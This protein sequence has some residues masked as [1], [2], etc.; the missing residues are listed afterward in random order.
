[1]NE[2]CNQIH[3]LPLKLYFKS[4][5]FCARPLNNPTW[6]ALLE[7]NENWFVFLPC[8]M[9]PV[10]KIPHQRSCE[11]RVASYSQSK[12]WQSKRT[13][14]TKM[15]GGSHINI[16]R[17][18]NIIAV[19]IS[20]WSDYPGIGIN[21]VY[22]VCFLCVGVIHVWPAFR[23][24]VSCLNLCLFDLQLLPRNRTTCV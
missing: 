1:M 10:I 15:F 5:Q 17:F 13:T 19:V 7:G 18:R 4:Y 14:Y 12:I 24:S 22:N 3:L 9:A 16:C 21:I 11:E 8:M 6:K 2:V 23:V 20:I